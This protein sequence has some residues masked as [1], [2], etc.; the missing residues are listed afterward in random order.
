MISATLLTYPNLPTIYM[1]TFFNT[2]AES[3]TFW[4]LLTTLTKQIPQMSND[5]LSGYFYAS[6]T[7]GAGR[8]SIRGG[9]LAPGKTIA[10]AWAIFDPLYKAIQA[11]GWADHVELSNYTAALDSYCTT[12]GQHTPETVGFD[13]RLSSRLF[14]LPALTGDFNTLKTTLKNAMPPINREIIAHLVTQPG[15]PNIA[16]PG[17]NAVLPA[18]RK[19]WAHFVVTAIWEPLNPTSEN[20]ELTTLK[21][22]TAAFKK[23]TPN[24]GAYLS[25]SDPSETD[26]KNQYFGS[27]YAR[28]LSIKN[29]YDPKGVFWCKPCVGNDQWTIMG[30]DGIGQHGGTICKLA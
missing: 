24:M 8:S 12:W 10:Q 29:R 13:G 18:W 5:G 27:N 28:L 4:N 2:T 14:D 6:A 22:N 19:T 26:W 21:A 25:E 23:Y 30:G 11:G 15:V 17:G 3:E 9:V 16:V 7:D 1:Q 20:Y